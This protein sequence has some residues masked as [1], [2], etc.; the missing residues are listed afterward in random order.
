M[1]PN[2]LRRFFVVCNNNNNNDNDSFT[3]LE[4][5]VVTLDVY[6]FLCDPFGV[7]DQYHRSTSFT[8][9]IASLPIKHR[10]ELQLF[11]FASYRCQLSAI[12]YGKSIHTTE[13]C[14]NLTHC[15]RKLSV[16]PSF[17]AKKVAKFQIYPKCNTSSNS[18]LVYNRDVE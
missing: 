14:I 18:H 1:T 11:F 13:K 6:I 7:L 4:K 2:E 15:N 16:A 17:T 3:A 8:T 12:P 5:L 9:V 10:E